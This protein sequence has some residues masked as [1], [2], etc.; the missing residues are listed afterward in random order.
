M[1]S[2][3]SEDKESSYVAVRLLSGLKEV[4]TFKELE[5]LL[6]I[7]AQGFSG[8]TRATFSSQKEAPRRSS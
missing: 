8:G 7:P 1:P 3:S 6:D 2:N 5:E 4:Y